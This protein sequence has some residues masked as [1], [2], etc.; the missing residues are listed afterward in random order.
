MLRLRAHRC[1]W[2]PLLEAGPRPDI[3]EV[4]VVSVSSGEPSY[5]AEVA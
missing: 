2:D 5:L 3:V 1:K 4:E